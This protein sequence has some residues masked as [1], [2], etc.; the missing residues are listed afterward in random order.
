MKLLKPQQE[1]L[2]KLGKRRR[3]WVEAWLV[4]GGGR[5]VGEDFRDWFSVTRNWYDGHVSL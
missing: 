5:L 2:A 1:G 3:S 4:G